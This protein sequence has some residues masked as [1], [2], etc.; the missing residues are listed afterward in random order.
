MRDLLSWVQPLWTSTST[1][2]NG[3]AAIEL[4]FIINGLQSLL[5]VL[6]TTV[7]YPP[8]S[9]KQRSRSK[10]RLRIPPVTGAGCA[11]AGTENTLIHPIKLLSILLT[12]QDLLPRL[13]RRVLALQPRLNALVLVIEIGH[14]HYQILNHEHVWQ[15]RYRGGGG[16][17]R[18]LSK[19]SEAVTA[20]DVHGAGA[21]DPFA[22]GAAEREGRVD[23][24]LDLD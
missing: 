21:A 1:V 16:F 7:A 14:V 17:F 4:E 12:L 8:I 13:L 19:A 10:I 23:L 18:D 6:I 20:V 11:T 5:S 22:A 15:R 3:V 24:V 2:Q 9:M